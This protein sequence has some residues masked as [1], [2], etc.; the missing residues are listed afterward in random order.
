[1]NKLK[2]SHKLLGGFLA[3]ALIAAII[4][5]IGIMKVHK[6]DTADSTLY[7]VGTKTIADMSDVIALIGDTRV[8]AR[9][10][11]FR[12][13]DAQ[14]VDALEAKLQEARVQANTAYE[15]LAKR[16]LSPAMKHAYEEMM[17]ERAP[18]REQIDNVMRY[19]RAGNKAAAM[20]ELD[21]NVGGKFRESIRK[22]QQVALKETEQLDTESDATARSA[23]VTLVIALILGVV[24]AVVL[25][26]M[27]SR[28]ITKPLDEM[29]HVAEALAEGDLTREVDHHSSDEIGK[30]AESFRQMIGFWSA[31]IHE[32]THSAQVLASSSEEL[33]AVSTQMG[34]N[35]QETS[36]QTNVVAAA[37]E[38]V[39]QNVSVVATGAEEMLASIRE[40]SKNANEA[41]RVA[42][43]AVGTADSTNQTISKLGESSAEI[44]NVVKV[45]TSIAQQTNLLA[46]NATIEAARAGEAGKGFAVVANEVKEL[47]KQTAKATSEI[48][49]KIEAI[50]GDTQRSVQAIGEIT[51][52]I[53]QINEISHTIATAVEEQTAT[54]NEMSRNVTEAAKGSGEISKNIAGVANAAASTTSGA[55]DTQKAAKELGQMAAQLQK[56]VSKFSIEQ[57]DGGSN[58][59]RGLQRDS[60]WSNRRVA[61][62]SPSAV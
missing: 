7:E 53:N 34:S 40:I 5:G 9:D 16:Q 46:L 39:S 22:V 21:K 47:A 13:K 20:A 62:L 33:S 37:T 49:C 3:V 12:A 14:E 17:A 11:A 51:S 54:T 36:T 26:L 32:L 2:V 52:I 59:P 57:S 55:A 25:G 35:A 1:M 60:A 58:R 44:G 18:F 10:A 30:L 29:T 42:G 31:T 24:V 23:F 61:D 48:G 28:A 19:A 38:Q 27:I 4:G 56:L 43:N 50:Q 41:A 45:I 8:A 6:L 15:D